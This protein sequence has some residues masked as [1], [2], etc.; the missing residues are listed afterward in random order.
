MCLTIDMC[1]VFDD[2]VFVPYGM[3]R[4]IK[5]LAIVVSYFSCHVSLMSFS[6]VSLLV[7]IS[8]MCI[9]NNYN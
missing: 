1:I 8:N 2:Y 3:W 6:V 7:L 9:V 5:C 4:T